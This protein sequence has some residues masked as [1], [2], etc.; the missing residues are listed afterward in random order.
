MGTD[1]L[2]SLHQDLG[3]ADSGADIGLNGFDLAGRLSDLTGTPAGHHYHALDVG[4]ASLIN[5]A[6]LFTEKL[7]DGRPR[8]L[9]DIVI[10][11]VRPTYSLHIEALERIPQPKQIHSADARLDAITDT[12]LLPWRG[13]IQ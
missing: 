8:P 9:A 13:S 7:L 12:C 11:D 2:G 6:H 3:L 1:V 10:D 5:R 4:H